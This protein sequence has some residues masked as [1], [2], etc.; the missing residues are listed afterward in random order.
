MPIP[1]VVAADESFAVG[2]GVLMQSVIETTSER[3][4]FYFFHDALTPASRALI[5]QTVA[6]SSRSDL[7]MV[8][9]GRALAA[10]PAPQR[11]D[12]YT[13]M[14]YARLLTPDY[15]PADRAIYLDSDTLVRADINTL[16]QH[17]MAGRPVAAVRD[18]AAVRLSLRSQVERDYFNDATDGRG[19]DD[20]FNAGVLLLD[21]AR[22]RREGQLQRSLE[23]V[24]SS[25]KLR[26]ADQCALNLAIRGQYTPLAER[27]N[28]NVAHQGMTRDPLAPASLRQRVQAAFD[29]PAVLHYVGPKPWTMF[30]T[31]LKREHQEVLRRS[32]W[33]NYRQPM[34]TLSWQQKQ[35]LIKAWRS[36]AVSVRI[37]S[38]EVNIQLLG[39]QLVH[40]TRAEPT[41]SKA[42]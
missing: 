4:H 2:A 7:T 38:S 42:A 29:A 40:W 24:A 14:T 9:A 23:L 22:L 33:R 11:T 6:A 13:K 21:L 36:R 15:V 32:P 31:V 30:P 12:A 10:L 41:P 37:R 3:V 16:F 28:T 27:W 19:V 17:D 1:I 34:S 18:Y 5:E 26:F 8:D 39:R 35:Q 20:Y 25:R